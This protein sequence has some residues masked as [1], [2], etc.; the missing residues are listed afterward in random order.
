MASVTQIEQKVTAL[1]Q[2]IADEFD[3][4]RHEFGLGPA[5]SLPWTAITGR[6]LAF[7]SDW[8]IVD[9]KP[10]TFPPSAHAHLTTDITD[11]TDAVNILIAASGGGGGGGGGGE[12]FQFDNSTNSGLLALFEDS[13]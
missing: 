8:A 10:L 4:I 12:G 9:N 7:P 11:F 2:R 1:A 5:A 13:F 6:P 3:A